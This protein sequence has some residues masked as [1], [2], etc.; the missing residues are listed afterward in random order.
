MA[1]THGGQ[2][3][4]VA[5]QYN[6]P[7]HHWLD[8]ST[9]IAPIAYQIPTIAEEYWQQL[10]NIDDSLISAAKQY[11]QTKFVIATNG[12]QAIIKALPSLYLTSLQAKSCSELTVYLPKVGYK[13]HEHAWRQTGANIVLYGVTLPPIEQL[14]END[15]VVVINPNNPSGKHFNKSEL[16]KYHQ[17]LIKLNGLLVVDEAFADVTANEHSL[18]TDSELGHLVVLRSFGKFFGLAGIRI[19]FSCCDSNW[20]HKFLEALGPWQV[21]GPAQV[22]AE[23]ALND[24]N[25]QAQQRE[26]LSAL[27]QQQQTLLQTVFSPLKIVKAT[28]C[29]LFITLYF[30]DKSIAPKLYHQLCQQAVYCRLTDEQDSLRFGIT[31][32][33]NFNKLEQ[34][35]KNAIEK[36]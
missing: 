22:I 10:P 24:T 25:W 9:G 29:D 28:G 19:G 33:A 26:R 30:S 1:L 6:I 21:N 3:A 13:E 12:S 5:K 32:T 11:Y 14:S 4:T 23:K 31:T 34:A 7:E 35:C 2:L 27:R 16:S 15:V 17:K 8:L 18:T 36:L 20:Q